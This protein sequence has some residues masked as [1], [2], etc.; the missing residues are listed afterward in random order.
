MTSST[1]DI[2]DY[3]QSKRE[4]KVYTGLFQDDSGEPDFKGLGPLL[5]GMVY[6]FLFSM[7]MSL[8]E[9][10]YYFAVLLFLFFIGRSLSA[11]RLFYVEP[12]QRNGQDSYFIHMNVLQNFVEGFVALF[13]A[14]YVLVGHILAKKNITGKR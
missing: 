5:K 10:N 14:V 7:I 9:I 12:L 11:I 4:L 8:P 3:N 13:V 1:Y 2:P 6:V